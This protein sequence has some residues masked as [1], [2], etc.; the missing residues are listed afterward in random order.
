ML[1]DADTGKSKKIADGAA[2]VWSPSGDWIA[3]LT[4]KSEVS[5]LNL[6]TGASR[7]ID[8][9]QTSGFPIEWSPAGEYLLIRK[10]QALPLYEG[11]LWVYRI[12]DG[13]WAP[14]PYTAT[15][16]LQ[17]HWFHMPIN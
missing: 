13:T 17:W 16:L 3:Y 9:G 8:A 12:S 15:P 6:A 2:A 5:L 1:L 10:Q 14:L 4:L 11:R 7:R